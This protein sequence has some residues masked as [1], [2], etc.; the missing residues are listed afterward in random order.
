[1]RKIFLVISILTV[2]NCYANVPIDT[3]LDTAN[4]SAVKAAVDQ[5]KTY[6]KQIQS[7]KTVY[8]QVQ[9]LKG[10]QAL[11]AGGNGVC[12]LCN[13]STSTEIHDYVQNI[14]GDLCSQFSNA[15]TNLTGAQANIDSIGGI[16]DS[17][18][19]GMSAQG[20][21]ISLASSSAA[22]LTNINSTMAQIQL[23]QTQSIQ[24]KL[25]EEKQTT[26]NISDASE[27][28]TGL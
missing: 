19:S 28:R 24:K 11:Q 14:N 25:A 3:S 2:F 22:T 23:L 8:D 18:S 16:I 12:N 7:A 13:K 6:A 15:L 20:A 9:G 1:M 4:L 26:A 5:A 21:S 10:L 27:G 17:I